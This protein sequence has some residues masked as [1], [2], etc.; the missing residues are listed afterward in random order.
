[1]RSVTEIGYSRPFSIPVVP[2]VTK[3]AAHVLTPLNPSSLVLSEAF[4]NTTNKDWLKK[5]QKEQKEL[6][7]SPSFFNLIVLVCFLKVSQ[8][9]SQLRK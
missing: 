3:T 5:T 6:A 9:P 1:M 4:M 2:A 8:S 7:I